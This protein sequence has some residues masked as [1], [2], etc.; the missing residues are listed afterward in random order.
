[1]GDLGKQRIE[2]QSRRKERAR[3]REKCFRDYIKKK[4]K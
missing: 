2:E 3:T 1:M 4:N